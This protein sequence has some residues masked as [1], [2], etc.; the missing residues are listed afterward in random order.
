MKNVVLLLVIL[1]SAFVVNAQ[2]AEK[3]SRKELKA[4]REALQVE[5]TQKMIESKRFEFIPDRAYTAR[6]KSV[7]ITSY[8][9][10]LK[11]DTIVSYLPF[12]GRAYVADYGSTSSPFN[13]T[14]TIDSYKEPDV[15]KGHQIELEVKQG[16]DNL[17]YRF[18]IFENGSTSLDINSTNRQTMSYSGRIEEI[19]KKK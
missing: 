15:K 7:S 9:V 8:S 17:T 4:E 5:L 11:G 6:G 19:K 1:F 2:E 13:F 18:L 14:S 12:Y 16:S 3:K 10:E